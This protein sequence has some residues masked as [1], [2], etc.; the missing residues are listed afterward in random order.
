MAFR[1]SSIVVVLA[2]AACGGKSSKSVDAPNGTGDDAMTDGPASAMGDAP[3]GDGAR[4]TGDARSG[5]GITCGAAT[6]TDTTQ[7]CCLG[8]GGQETCVAAGTCTGVAFACDASED[9]PTNDVCCYSAGGTGAGTSC[10]PANQCQTAACH[11][12][13]DCTGTA[14]HCCPIGTTGFSVCSAQPC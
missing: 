6:C 3:P 11:T 10:K 9:C 7:V 12:N 13:D 4:S 14:S 1:I 2:L 8:T 5:V